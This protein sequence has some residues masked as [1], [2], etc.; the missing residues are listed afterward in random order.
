MKHS[1]SKIAQ[2]IALVG[3]VTI[4]SACAT[5]PTGRNQIILYPDAQLDAMGEQAFAGMKEGIKISTKLVENQLV[6]CI[7]SKI[8]AQVPKSV[9]SGEWEVVVFDDPQVNAFAL[10]G[11]KIGVYTG[12]LSVAQN[13]HQVASVI[14]HEVGHVIARHSN[15]RM[16]NSEMV[17]VLQQ[18]TGQILAAYEVAQS[19]LLMQI[20][21]VGAQFGILKYSRVHES[22]ADVI[23]LDLMA[24]AGFAP[25]GAVE[26]W[27]NMAAQGGE[28]P[29]E[30]LSTHPSE[31]TRIKNLE[32]KLPAANKIYQQ[33]KK[34]NCER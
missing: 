25:I 8:T 28:R 7:A 4:V 9:F 20:L 30:F 11:G 22:E 1:L 21:G 16:S 26:L 27:N 3:A 24:K 32:R 19:P 13:Q 12:L 17:G 15:E 2:T 31:S 23:G 6:Q 33:S 10:P 5:S 34:A 18:S 29:P 14:G